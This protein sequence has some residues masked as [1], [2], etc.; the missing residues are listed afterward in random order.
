[1][2]RNCASS[3][4]IRIEVWGVSFSPDGKTVASASSDKTIK[5]WNVA[6]GKQ[7]RT[8]RGHQACGL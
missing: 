5:L 6:D 1:M 8:L 3:E 4:G 7:L 2:A